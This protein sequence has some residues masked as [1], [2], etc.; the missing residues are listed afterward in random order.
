MDNS[1]PEDE[2]DF[3][4]FILPNFDLFSERENVISWL[5]NTEAKFNQF[6]TSRDLRL[7]AVPLLVEG[8]AKRKYIRNRHAIKSFD[9]FYEFC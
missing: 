6:H 1:Q 2:I 3:D 7:T 9:D 8:E 5:D 4:A